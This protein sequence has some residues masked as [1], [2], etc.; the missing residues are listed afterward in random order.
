MSKS[1]SPLESLRQYLP[2]ASFELVIPYIVD[3]KVH[4]T[5]TRARTTILGNYIGKHRD[6]N[7]R[8]SIN[9]NLNKFSFLITLLHEIA[10]LLAFE[11]Y[12]N[13][14]KAH[15]TEWKREY[16]Q[17]LALFLLKKIFPKDIEEELM[18]TLKNPAASSCAE[19]ELLR[20]LRKYDV[21]NSHLLLEQLKE[22]DFFKIK[23]GRVFQKGNKVRTRYLCREV[24]TKKLF[25]FSPV[26]EVLLVN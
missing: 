23:S 16:S 20:V 9:G 12:G 11:K 14:I 5:I 1:T 21:G 7:H 4:L 18:R 13:T 26:S 6:R 15:G 3:H 2:E 25:L 19:K 24:A 17:V 8:I 10:H 22:D